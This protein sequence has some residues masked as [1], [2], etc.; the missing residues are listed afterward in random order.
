VAS[1]CSASA[2]GVSGSTTITGGTLQTD[3]GDSEPSNS[4]P[5]HPPVNVAVPTN[6][7]A[8]AS[9]DG[10]T[11]IG[12]TTDSIRYVFNE[13][14]V[15]PDGSITVNAAHQYLLGPTAVGDVIIGQ[16][17]CGVI[18]PTDTTAPSGDGQP[19]ERPGRPDQQ[20]ADQLHRHLQRGSQRLRQQRRH[21]RRHRRRHA[22]GGS[23][24]WADRFQRRRDRDDER[25]HRH[26]L[27]PSPAPPPTPPATPTPPPPAPTTPSP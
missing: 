1:S 19:G 27:H 23:D 3:N 26:R 24:R 2:T 6:P 13:Q 14:T 18:V 12:N 20:L 17:R 21:P 16:S 4:I 11:H 15:N 5:D 9:Y 10:H 25:Q 22:R 8:N 7:A